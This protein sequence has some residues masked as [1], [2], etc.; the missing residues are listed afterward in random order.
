M[1][2]EGRTHDNSK[3]D[4]RKKVITNKIFLNPEF[5]LISKVNPAC[6]LVALSASHY[7]FHSTW[8]KKLVHC[9][10][11]SVKERQQNIKMYT[12]SLFFHFILSEKDWAM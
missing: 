9:L 7:S 1:H 5:L 10:E 6:L 2:R 8:P 12:D 11:A 3:K 4:I